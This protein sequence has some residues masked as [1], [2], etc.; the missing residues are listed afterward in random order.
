MI[1]EFYSSFLLIRQKTYI[2]NKSR[3][4][5]TRKPTMHDHDASFPLPHV[6][7]SGMI[8]SITTY[9]I[10][11]AANA[12]AYGNIGFIIPTNNAPR[13]PAIGSTNPLSCPYHILFAAENPAVFKGRLTAR[14]SGKFCI[15]I[16]IAKFRA[17]SKVAVSALSTEPNATPTAKPKNQHH[18]FRSGS[19]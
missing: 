19:F 6:C 4:I 5:I 8:S 12:K 14:P 13:T 15:P 2:G 3:D 7:A 18:E 1:C 9:T 11:P 16:P 17:F 10:A